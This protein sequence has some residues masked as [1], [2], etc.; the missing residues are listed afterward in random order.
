[1]KTFPLIYPVTS[2][3]DHVGQGSTFVAV[4]GFKENG[5]AYIPEALKRGATV[6]VVH[7]GVILTDDIKKLIES[8]KAQIRYVDSAREALAQLSAKAYGY[9]A[10]SLKIIGITGTKGKTTTT[11]LLDHILRT[12]GLKTARLSTVKNRILDT[13]YEAPLTTPQPDYLHTFFSLCKQEGVEVVIMEVAAQALS[14]NRVDTLE[15]DSVVFTNFSL[16]HS[17]FYRSMDEYFAAKCLLLDLLAKDGVIVLNADDE[18]VAALGQRYANV[19]TISLHQAATYKGTLKESSLSALRLDVESSGKLYQLVSSNLLGEFSGY[20][21]LAC[22]AAAARYGVSPEVIQ[23]ALHSFEGVPG[24]LNCYRLPNGALAVID[25][26]HTPSSFEAF[27][28]AVRPLSNDIIAVFGAGGDRDPNKRP[29]MG[30]LAGEYADKI[31][32]TMD[33]PRSEDVQNITKDILDG[34]PENVRYKV[35]VIYD[36]EEAIRKAYAQ[37][38]SGSMLV[39][40]GKGPVEY[41]HVKDVKIPFSEASILRS[42]RS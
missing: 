37:S 22:C 40:L 23:K 30:A 11:Y 27:F 32:L 41:Q 5:V 2:H 10:N 28:K 7:E 20:N 19:T 38:G 6:I 33:N 34:I 39:L 3:T 21:L 15:F 18:K 31:I 24:R 1:M 9:P 25:N 36:R 16:E 12:A 8:H 13:E 42:L 17:E 26:A 4:Q 14:M 29:L 35:K